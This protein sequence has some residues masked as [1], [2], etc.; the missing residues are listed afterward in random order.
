MGTRIRDSGKTP[1]SAIWFTY[2]RQTVSGKV[3]E[4]CPVERQQ[5]VPSPAHVIPATADDQRLVE[6]W[7]LVSRSRFAPQR[8]HRRGMN[9]GEK[10]APRVGPK[11]SSALA[12]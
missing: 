11:S 3:A 9:L 10:L 7:H 6:R 1:E 8:E 4:S 12:T 5:I 2:L